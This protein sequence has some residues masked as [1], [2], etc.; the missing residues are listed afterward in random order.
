MQRFYAK[1]I[2]WIGDDE[3]L[4][5]ADAFFSQFGPEVVVTVHPA[6][7][8]MPGVVTVIHAEWSIAICDGTRTPQQLALQGFTAMSAPTNYGAFGTVP[9]WYAA[10]SWINGHLDADGMVAGTP[11]L[12]VGHS[13]G[14]AAMMVLAARYR[15]ADAAR[16]I[17]FITFGAPKPGDARLEALLALCSGLTIANDGDIVTVFPPDYLT[18]LPVMLAL[19]APWM[20][21]YADY[22]RPPYQSMQD[23]FGTLHPTTF[24][25]LDTLTLTLMVT[26]VLA[27]LPQEPI[28][29]HRITEYSRRIARRCPDAEWPVSEDT[30]DILDTTIGDVGLVAP[31][32]PQDGWIG[33][34]AG[35]RV[36]KAT[37]NLG[38]VGP[39]KTVEPLGLTAPTTAQKGALGLAAYDLPIHVV[40]GTSCADVDNPFL[41]W[42]TW[43][44]LDAA[45]AGSRWFRM[46]GTDPPE[47]G[48]Y[49]F[50]LSLTPSGTIHEVNVLQGL[51][52]DLNGAGS[53]DTTGNHDYVSSPDYPPSF[54]VNVIVDEAIQIKFRIWNFELP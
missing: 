47:P 14:G 3:Q 29:E 21:V 22:V 17:R 42:N 35:K 27:S 2:E 24:P 40:G 45:G 30:I 37:G 16:D 51:C 50:E 8:L 43:Y 54:H 23:R 6:E 13:Y 15:H 36:W 48:S 38:L 53:G 9:L 19:G 18:L 44:S 31:L 7:G 46:T 32:K 1:V 26:N 52:S 28:F 11:I 25:L 49:E 12:L 20:V 4:L 39:M 33:L 34:E 5:I 41:L 10:S